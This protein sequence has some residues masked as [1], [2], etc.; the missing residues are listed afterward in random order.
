MS[1]FIGID[2]LAITTFLGLLF[3]LGA[4]GPLDIGLIIFLGVF[5]LFGFFLL[6]LGIIHKK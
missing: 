4:T 3:S 5:Y 2:W 1:I 6:S